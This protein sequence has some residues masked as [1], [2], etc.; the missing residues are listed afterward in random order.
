MADLI[1][2]GDI[3]GYKLEYGREPLDFS[4]NCN[5]LGIPESI[6]EAIFEAAKS[7]DRYPDPLCRRLRA[8][9]SDKIGVPE[10]QILC[11]NG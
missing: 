6:P 4:A 10:E 7:A 11:G 8:A 5:P 3:E 2:G 9:L 1:H